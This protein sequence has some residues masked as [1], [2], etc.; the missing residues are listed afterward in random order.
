MQCNQD[1]VWRQKAKAIYGI[2]AMH[3]IDGVLVGGASLIPGIEFRGI[4]WSVFFK[5]VH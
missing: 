2:I 4:I 3:D 1:S 5:N